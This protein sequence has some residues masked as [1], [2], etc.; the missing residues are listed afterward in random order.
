MVD[1][2]DPNVLIKSRGAEFLIGFDTDRKFATG[3][4]VFNQGSFQ[5][6]VF[7]EQS[8]LMTPEGEQLEAVKNVASVVMP[9]AVAQQ[10]H[11]I[12]G[13]A[14]AMGEPDAGK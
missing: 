10:F 13:E 5:L 14:L 1:S 3:V 11:K 8:L 7:R 2:P 6:I 4:Q 12:L 9:T